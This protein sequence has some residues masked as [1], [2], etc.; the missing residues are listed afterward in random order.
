MRHWVTT[1][2]GR[3]RRY[4]VEDLSARP[5]GVT[6][7][8]L[9]DLSVRVLRHYMGKGD[10]TLQRDLIELERLD[11]VHRVGDKFVATKI[12]LAYLPPE[13]A[14]T[15]G[16]PTTHTPAALVLLPIC[17]SFAIFLWPTN[18]RENSVEVFNAVSSSLISRARRE[19]VN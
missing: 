1:E 14:I 2:T 3:R 12:D 6:K 8:K 4:L 13:K 9:T 16:R 19:P 17:G 15:E 7:S 18:A 5:E 10:K 11:L